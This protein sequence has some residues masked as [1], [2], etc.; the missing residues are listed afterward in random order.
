MDNPISKQDY[1]RESTS[2]SKTETKK[3]SKDTENS[4]NESLYT[5]EKIVGH[6]YKMGRLLFEFTWYGYEN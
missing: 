3:E 5:V 1:L 2:V 6:E 4:K